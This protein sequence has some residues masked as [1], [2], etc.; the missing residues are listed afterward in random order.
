MRGQSGEGWVYGLG[1]DKRCGRRSIGGGV[2][3][4]EGNRVGWRFAE[5]YIHIS[6]YWP[7][8]GKVWLAGDFRMSTALC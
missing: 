3:G 4:G 8:K 7:R 5:Q 1:Q 2:G 6:Q